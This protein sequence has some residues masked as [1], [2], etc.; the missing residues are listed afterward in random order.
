MLRGTRLVGRNHLHKR[1]KQSVYGFADPVALPMVGGCYFKL[2]IVLS[3]I[4]GGR[5]RLITRA[6]VSP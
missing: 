4:A 3:V 1:Y 2:A 5:S 6:G